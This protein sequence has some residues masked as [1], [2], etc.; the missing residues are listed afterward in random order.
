VS[1]SD[2][3]A[4]LKASGDCH[5]EKPQERA[6]RARPLQKTRAQAGVPVPQREDFTTEV[7]EESRGS[8]GRGGDGG[9][10]G[11]GSGAQAGVPVPQQSGGVEAPD[12]DEGQE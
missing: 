9:V 5:K 6:G 3:S 10:R 1:A 12:Y 4:A 2:A 11:E 7:T 8:G